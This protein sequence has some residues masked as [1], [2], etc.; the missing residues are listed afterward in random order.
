MSS[1]EA[2]VYAGV[3]EDTGKMVPTGYVIANLCK[4]LISEDV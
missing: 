3:I 1:L 2:L 4:I